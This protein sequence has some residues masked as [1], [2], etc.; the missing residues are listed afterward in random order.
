MNVLMLVDVMSRFVGTTQDHLDAFTDYSQ[1]SI[2]QIHIGKFKKM[3]I[4]MARFDCVVFHYSIPIGKSA[5]IDDDMINEFSRYEGLVALFIQDEMRWVNSAINKIKALRVS[6]IFTV[7]SKEAVRK[8]Y[9][10]PYFDTVRFEHVLTGYVPEKLLTVDA[11]AYKDR[12]IDVSYRARKLSAGYGEFGQE[13]FRIADRFKKDAV[14]TGLICD[15]SC[16]ERDRLYGQKW[17]ELL[18]NSKATLGAESGASFIDF[19]GQVHSIVEKYE[20]HHPEKT[21][22]EVRDLFLEGRDGDIIIRAISPRCFE[23]AALR[24]LMI[25]YEGSYSDVLT[26]HR[27]YVV[28]SKDHSNFQEV[29]DIIGDPTRAAE[30]IENAYREVACSWKWSYRSMVNQFD[31][32]IYEEWERKQLAAAVPLTKEERS[33]FV[34]SPEWL[35]R[36][37]NVA[38]WL[39]RMHGGIIDNLHGPMG[40]M[41]KKTYLMSSMPLKK[42]L[43]RLLSL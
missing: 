40:N 13:K 6:L 10:D 1:H 20:M 26:P 5:F 18:T 42:I 38:L 14:G 31:N 35:K 7:T 27:H 9:H 32:A 24:T 19:S 36:K 43:K 17:I 41:M 30:I 33:V 21:F 8:I 2:F 29:L 28:L 37:L 39:T 3:N 15:I 11:I 4:N 23:A 25:M 16:L 34:Q 22:E 12:K